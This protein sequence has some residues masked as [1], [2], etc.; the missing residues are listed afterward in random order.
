MP[1]RS[2]QRPNPI[3]KPLILVGAILFLHAA[4]STYEH[5]SIAK[6]VGLSQAKVPLDITIETAVSLLVLV[7]GLLL[8]SHPLREITWAAEM[9]KRSID[10]IEAKTNFA[11]FNH[12][13]PFL[14]GHAK[15]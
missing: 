8:S 2:N 3:G 7:V 6:T 9:Q 11:T 4:Y 5:S 14:F 10:E 12:R 15:K 13:G 1:A